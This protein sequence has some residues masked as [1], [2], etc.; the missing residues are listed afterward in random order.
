MGKIVKVEIN[1]TVYSVNAQ[2]L[3]YTQPITQWH[4]RGEQE[5]FEYQ[6]EDGSSIRATA[7]HRFMTIQGEML[8][9]QDIFEQGLDLH[10]LSVSSALLLCN[11]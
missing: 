5:V 8:P 4:D 2:G 1:C 3:V 10:K 11:P 9:I 7:N 6:L